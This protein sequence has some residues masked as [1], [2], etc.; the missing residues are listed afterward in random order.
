MVITHVITM[1]KHQQTQ[2]DTLQS[3]KSLLQHSN[4]TR[5]NL[6]IDFRIYNF[7]TPKF[8]HALG[9]VPQKFKSKHVSKSQVNLNFVEYTEVRM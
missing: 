6:F 3:G 1:R 5:Q 8:Y 9:L 7:T 4:K 2:K